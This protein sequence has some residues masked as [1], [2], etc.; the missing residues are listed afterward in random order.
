MNEQECPY[1]DET[2]GEH[3]GH[4]NSCVEEAPL[5]GWECCGD[6]EVVPFD[7]E[8]CEGV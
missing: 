5:T 4:C 3:V 6:G 1:I 7:D 8:K 2:T